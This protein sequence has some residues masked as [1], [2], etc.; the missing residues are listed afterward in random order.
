MCVRVLKYFCVA[1]M[2]VSVCVSMSVCLCVSVS[3]SVYVCVC[4]AWHACL[5][6][7]LWWHDVVRWHDVCHTV[8]AQGPK[9]NDIKQK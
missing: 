9:A 3:V 8:C 2:C 1:A 5:S 7:Y 4:I 6:T